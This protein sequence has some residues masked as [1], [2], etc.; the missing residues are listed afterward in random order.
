M[1][2]KNIILY[3]YIYIY[4]FEWRLQFLLLYQA[5]ISLEWAVLL[6][7]LWEEKKCSHISH[8]SKVQIFFLLHNFTN[9][10]KRCHDS[11]DLTISTCQYYFCGVCARVFVC[12]C[13]FGFNLSQKLFLKRFGNKKILFIWWILPYKYKCFYIDI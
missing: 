11:D 2:S 3:I 1:I 9:N 5:I 7:L 4:V 8:K 13:F 12:V 10:L 6:I